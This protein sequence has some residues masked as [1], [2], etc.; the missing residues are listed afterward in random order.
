MLGNPE[1]GRERL[2]LV[3][4]GSSIPFQRQSLQKAIEL[5]HKGVRIFMA[6]A[7]HSDDGPE[8]RGAKR[9]LSPPTLANFVH[10]HW[11][12]LDSKLSNYT[13]LAI[14]RSC[15]MTES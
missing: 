7:S 15:P 10:I 4:T 8:A 6:V 12:D 5:S 11:S 13:G 2:V 1:R 3:V 9:V 14:T